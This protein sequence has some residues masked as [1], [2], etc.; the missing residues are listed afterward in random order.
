MK[1]E[2]EVSQGTSQRWRERT[3]E[4]SVSFL[5]VVTVLVS[6]DRASFGPGWLWIPCTAKDNLELLSLPPPAQ[7]LGLQFVPILSANFLFHWVVCVCVHAFTY[8]WWCACGRTPAEITSRSCFLLPR[9]DSKPLYTLALQHSFKWLAVNQGQK[10]DLP[11]PEKLD[12][13]WKLNSSVTI[14]PQTSPPKL[15]HFVLFTSGDS[16]YCLLPA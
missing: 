3:R 13:D 11:Y 2:D 12:L 7:G 14:W 5:T 15:L 10:G 4:N 6:W 9:F 8:A 16:S 1:V